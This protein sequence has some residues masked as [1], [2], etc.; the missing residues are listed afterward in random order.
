MDAPGASPTRHA[1][2][3]TMH[4]SHRSVPDSYQADRAM[5]G[6]SAP[7]GRGQSSTEGFLREFT[8]VAEAAKRAQMALMIQDFESC[9][10][11]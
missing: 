10:L 1:A 8:L 7:V 5:N 2:P 4:I 9:G 6:S 11:S 3:S